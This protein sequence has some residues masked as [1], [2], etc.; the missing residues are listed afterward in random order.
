MQFIKFRIE[1]CF[2]FLFTH[3]FSLQLYTFANTK[4]INKINFHFTTVLPTF[5][6]LKKSGFLNIFIYGK[7]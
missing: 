4:E 2:L 5:A 6:V 3:A 1:L 7:P